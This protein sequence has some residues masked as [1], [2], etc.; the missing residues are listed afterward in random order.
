VHLALNDK[1]SAVS[2]MA[3]ALEADPDCQAALDAMAQMG[4][5]AVPEYL[6]GR[7]A[8]ATAKAEEKARAE[9]AA[10]AAEKARAEAAAKAEERGR[11]EAL[12]KIERAL[13][14]AD[15]PLQSP[16]GSEPPKVV[17]GL[18]DMAR[19]PEASDRQKQQMIE[20]G[21]KALAEETA[22]AA[23][24]APVEVPAQQKALTGATDIDVL[25]SLV[26][27][28]PE[29]PAREKVLTG[30][31]LDEALPKTKEIA[32]DDAAAKATARARSVR[33]G[34]LLAA[35]LIAVVLVILGQR[36][37]F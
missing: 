6:S 15:I 34:V 14:N 29:G 22:K 32:L 20:R 8:E 37:F 30:A 16:D 24:R 35:L 11:V 36:I 28:E 27:L 17:P 33:Q 25:L 21:K 31:A 10:K 26:D 5:L 3:L 4:I 12:A 1:D 9:A 13:S 18:L 19:L 7:R 23:E 2:E